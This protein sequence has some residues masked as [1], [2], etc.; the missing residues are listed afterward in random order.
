M[1]AAGGDFA[2]HMRIWPSP[3]RRQIVR[4]LF[5]S[6]RRLESLRGCYHR[7]RMSDANAEADSPMTGS[8]GLA[9]LIE[10][11]ERLHREHTVAFIAAG[12]EKIY[13][14]G[15]GGYVAILSDEVFRGAVDIET[16]TGAFR[17]EP[18][19]DG[20]PAA[21]PTADGELLDD[22]ELDAAAAGFER[23]YARRVGQV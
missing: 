10:V 6:R 16:P 15:G 12:D 3:A 18:G 7:R 2:S 22:A 21:A 8:A 1:R 4:E 13:S 5:N 20:R 19:E 23:Y 9:R 14:Y 11:V 17:I